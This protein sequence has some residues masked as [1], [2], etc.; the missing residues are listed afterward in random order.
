[1]KAVIPFIILSAVTECKLRDAQ[2][3]REPVRLSVREPVLDL[4]Q[5][6]QRDIL[7][8]AM[9]YTDRTTSYREGTRPMRPTEYGDPELDRAVITLTDIDRL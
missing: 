8:A 6:P 1:M 2:K 4:S 3:T 7:N 9:N 5:T